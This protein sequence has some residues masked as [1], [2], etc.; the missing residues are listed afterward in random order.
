MFNTPLRPLPPKNY[1]PPL[2]AREGSLSGFF[3]IPAQKPEG[4]AI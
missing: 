3:A 1:A 4:T 2:F